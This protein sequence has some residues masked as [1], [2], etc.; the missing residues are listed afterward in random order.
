MKYTEQGESQVANI[1]STSKAEYYVYL[2]QDIHSPNAVYFKQKKQQCF[3]YFT[4]MLAT[5]EIMYHARL[6]FLCN[7]STV[8]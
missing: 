4:L 8:Y 7:L 1:R 6:I 2:S 3:K 5:V